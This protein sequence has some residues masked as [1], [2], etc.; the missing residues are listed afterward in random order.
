MNLRIPFPVEQFLVTGK[1]RISFL[2]NFS[3][4]DVSKLSSG[5]GVETFFPNVKGRIV[6]HGWIHLLP[7]AALLTIGRGTGETL[8]PHLERYVITEDVTFTRKPLE[9]AWLV[10]GEQAA[11]PLLECLKTNRPAGELDLTRHRLIVESDGMAATLPGWSQPVIAVF[12]DETSGEL[13]RQIE[14]VMPA[15]SGTPEDFYRF[16]AK[17]GMGWMGIDYS[18]ANLAQEAGRTEQAISFR[19]GC[20]LGQEPIARLDAMGHTN[21]ELIRLEGDELPT[22]PPG[23]S[24]A[25]SELFAEGEAKHVG[26]ITT[27]CHDKAGRTGS[28]LGYVKTKWQVDGLK[29]RVGSEEGPVVTVHTPLIPLGT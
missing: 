13:R 7:D 16:R 2:Q 10:V 21:R 19:K 4:N 26:T 5:E 12:F 15:E 9:E 18:D 27:F 1:H 14:G 6:G 8:I 11:T 3:T 25:G 29:L 20:Y 17:V 28:G 23:D 24:F 22:L